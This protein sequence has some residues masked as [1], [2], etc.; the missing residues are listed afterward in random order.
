MTRE[1]AQ[2]FID[3]YCVDAPSENALKNLM[4][5]NLDNR[6]IT[7]YADKSLVPR[8]YVTLVTDEYYYAAPQTFIDSLIYRD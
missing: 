1:Q 4:G 2:Q 7:R 3:S 5:L 8:H 6:R